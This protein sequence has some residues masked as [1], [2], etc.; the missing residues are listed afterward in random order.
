[1]RPRHRQVDRDPGQGGNGRTETATLTFK[2]VDIF[3][4]PLAGKQVNFTPSTAPS[5][6][7]S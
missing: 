1:M 5:P 6:S 7:T 2:V 4:N 3:G